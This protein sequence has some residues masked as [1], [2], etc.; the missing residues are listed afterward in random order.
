MVRMSRAVRCYGVGLVLALAVVSGCCAVGPRAATTQAATRPVV[1]APAATSAASPKA[2]TRPTAGGVPIRYEAEEQAVANGA[3]VK[4]DAT[5]SGSRYVEL[6]K[7]GRVRWTLTVPQA[8]R[9]EMV[10]RYRT[11]GSDR[12][13]SLVV[14]NQARGIG[15]PMTAGEWMEVT[16]VRPL[17]A[18]AN[19]V[20]L[21]AEW[22]EMDVDLLRFTPFPRGAVAP[23]VEYPAITPRRNTYY[24]G[25]EEPKLVLRTGGQV[26][27]AVT[28]GTHTLAV[29]SEPYA[30]I[31][32][33]LTVWLPGKALE[34]LPAGSHLLVF[35]FEGGVEVPFELEVAEKP[36]AM[37]WTIVTFDVSHGTSV[38]MKLPGGKTALIDTGTADA[39]RKV[40]LPFLQARGIAA[41]DYLILTHY[42]DDHAGGLPV[43]EKSITFG[44]RMDYKSFSAGDELE[45]DGLKVL[46]LNAF[47]SGTEENSRSLCL[48]FEKDG[49]VYLHG[50]DTYGHNQVQMLKQFPAERLR[51]QVFHANHHLHGSIDVGFYRTVDPA[52]VLV[53][54]EKA[55]YAR[56][57][58]TTWYQEGVEKYL[59]ANNARMRGTLLTAEV[60]SVVVRVRDAVHWSYETSGDVTKIMLP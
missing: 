1:N 24:R 36:V 54:A 3:A 22:G 55:V 44:K 40:V 31:D 8:G 9:Y 17:S 39:A 60:G 27:H 38:F 23:L 53:S 59:K 57:A 33:A 46:V 5:A 2:T 28:V 49:F 58:F 26:L 41:V 15:F 35:R 19:V 32:D 52:L 16:T 13:Q 18:G 6:G 12:A 37:P 14:N 42:H 51:A 21:A 4:D 7:K 11:G 29:K 45:L 34:E 56:G 50:G 43:L 20:E 47:A 25:G 48:R 30:A 10:L